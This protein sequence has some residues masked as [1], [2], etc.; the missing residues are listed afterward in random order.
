M[1]TRAIEITE[2]VVQ[3]MYYKKVLE[4]AKEGIEKGASFSKAF[5]ENFDNI[6]GKKKPKELWTDEDEKRI[7]QIGQNGNEGDHYNDEV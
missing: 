3:N 1:I 2:D 5:E 6:F 4:Q 7:D